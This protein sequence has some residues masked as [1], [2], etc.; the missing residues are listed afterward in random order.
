MLSGIPGIAWPPVAAGPVAVFA[1]YLRQFERIEW[2][3][4]KEIEAHQ[5]RQLPI[6]AA[7]A[8]E[9]S[10]QFRA[11]LKHA[12]LSPADLATPEGLAKLPVLTRRDVQTARDA[13]FCAT[14]PD[15]HAPIAE[16]R[17]SGSTGEP[18][19]VR[20]TAISQMD[21]LAMTMREHLW[22]RRDFTG[23]LAAIRANIAEYSERSDWGPPASLLFRT[24]GSAGIPITLDIARQFELLRAFGP[25]NLIIYPST[26]DA[27]ITHMRAHDLAL[28]TVRHVRTIGE[29]L[30]PRIRDEAKDVFGARVSD[31]YSS[32]EVGYVAIECPESGLYHVMAETMIVEILDGDGAPCREGE[33]GRV[34]VTDLHNFATPLIRYDIGDYAEVGGVCP[35][36]RGLPVLARIL[37][38]ER[39]LILMPDGSRHWPLTG[40]RRMRDIAP[41]SQY[42]LIQHDRERMEARLVVEK[43]LTPAQEDA[44]R[45]RIQKSLKY[46]FTIDLI[47]FE[48]RLPVG[49]NGKFEEFICKAKAD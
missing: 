4:R 12:Q 36:G 14:V 45:E 22:Q 21:W 29:T 43:K 19:V 11:R 42:Q 9:H 2:M 8:A 5:F 44:V 37:G 24:G 23:R 3:P 40:S 26:L 15:G 33:I 32:Q 7:H 17:T 20:R 25:D 30:S 6:L 41:V 48:D 35:C 10:K 13:L 47:Y 1:A 27:L 38:R 34:T 16:S 39:N 31:A 49:A 46:N 28:T 18:V